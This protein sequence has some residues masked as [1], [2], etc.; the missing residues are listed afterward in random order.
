MILAGLSHLMPI[1]FDWDAIIETMKNFQVALKE[2]E[3]LKGRT[4]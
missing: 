4:L 3:K 2:Q 1:R